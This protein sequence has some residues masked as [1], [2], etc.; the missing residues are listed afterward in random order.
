MTQTA[1]PEHQLLAATTD[2]LSAPKK[3]LIGGEWQAAA[4]GETFA[5]INPASG[6]RLA[7]VALAGQADVDRAVQA[8][9]RAFEGGPWPGLSGAERG[10]LLWRLADLME[11]HADELAELETLD[12]GKPI[13]ASRQGDLPLAVKHFRYYA[14]WAS[15]IEGA[16]I[17]VSAPNQFVYTL[18]EPVG[19]VGLII[20]WNFPLLMAA[21]KLAPA[22]AAGNTVILKPA[23]ETPLSAL[24][25]GELMVEAGFPPGVVNILTGPGLPTGAALTSHMGVDKIAFTGS[26][27]VGRQIMAA[28]AGSNLKRVSLE[29]GGKSPNVVFADADLEQA[30]RG[31][32]WAVFSTSGQE[33]V[34]GSRL[35]V[36]KPVYQQ[37]V[38]GLAAQAQRIRVGPGFAPKVHI[39]PIV[40]DRQLQ[41][42]LG[43]IE[44]G[45]QAGA[46]VVTGG[47]RLGGP[48]AGGYFVAPTIFTHQDDSLKLVQEE[49]FGP[50]VAVSPFESWDELVQRANQTR[51]GLAA[52]A[53]TR[54]V[55]KAHR[56]AHAVRAGTVWINSYGVFDPAAPFGGYKQS[57]F[58]RE[59]G[60][61][62]IEL[63]T[64]LKTVWVGL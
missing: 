61:E 41:T 1:A 45:R 35:F 14:G 46:Q 7:D 55:S 4:N 21:W 51:Y 54:D 36:E 22:L 57:G 19:V 17:P 15:K 44:S 6:E 20:P 30:I 37:V 25:L 58:G 56:F 27:E 18:R 48:L 49:I 9:R 12:N 38:D 2:F 32:T 28:A 63:Y 13:R 24:R 3:L 23:E 59:M 53:W 26:T 42:I 34:A 29:L 31:A 16:T 40:S 60:K 43:Y 10:N 11:A 5:S 52:G 33:C 39:G 47:E 8:A 50:V 64:E 62:A